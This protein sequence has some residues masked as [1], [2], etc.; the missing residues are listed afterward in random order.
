[1]VQSAVCILQ[2]FALAPTAFAFL[3][4]RS[5]G[6]SNVISSFKSKSPIILDAKV[7]GIYEFSGPTTGSDPPREIADL[8]GIKIKPDKKKSFKK[9]NTAAITPSKPAAAVAVAEKFVKP[10]PREAAK[11]RKSAANADFAE[12]LEDLEKHVLAKYGSNAFKDALNGDVDWDEMDD[13]RADERLQKK[14]KAG[15]F[16]GFDPAN[17]V[18]PAAV[19]PE[20]S[21]KK[22]KTETTDKKATDKKEKFSTEKA[23][24][25]SGIT[26]RDTPGKKSS[27]AKVIENPTLDDQEEYIYGAG[28][29][30]GTTVEK[31]EVKKSPVMLG[32][33]SRRKTDKTEQKKYS[34]DEMF[35]SEV[36]TVEVKSEKSLKSVKSFKRVVEE[37][38]EVEEE[39]EEDE[40]GR[41]LNM[42]RKDRRSKE[43]TWVGQKGDLKPKTKAPFLAESLYDYEGAEYDED[44]EASAAQRLK[45]SERSGPLNAVSGFRLRRPPPI[46]AEEQKKINDKEAALLAKEELQK[47]KRKMKKDL[48]KNLY[49][50]FE[51]RTSEE[52]EEFDQVFTTKSFTDIGVTDPIVLQNLERLNIFNPTKIQAASIPLMVDGTDVLL[53]AQTGSGKTLAFLLPLLNTVDK[54]KKKVSLKF[55]FIVIFFM[56]QLSLIWIYKKA[57]INI[58]NRYQS[59]VIMFIQ[60][61][62]SGKIKHKILFICFFSL[63][64]LITNNVHL[65]KLTNLFPKFF[66][67]S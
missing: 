27:R 6:Q 64:L 10:D 18:A 36:E 12:K 30:S 8:L 56:L 31:E 19:V 39:V 1:M 38:E 59:C 52:V 47:E 67:V 37:E 41:E 22:D 62:N 21:N 23:S 53:H 16:E 34:V 15:K 33:L 29:G 3:I 13:D 17:R 46:T 20:K 25:T 24:T 45:E 54:S 55:D 48:E 49:N 58:Y 57:F 14:A 26:S 35:D 61:E 42:A 63:Y 66:S 11:R 28:T 4:S 43:S 40:E 7:G 5:L 51:F 65:F 44:E 9:A 32:L 2:I 50:P 60:N